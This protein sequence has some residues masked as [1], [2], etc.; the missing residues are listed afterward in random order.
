MSNISAKSRRLVT[1]VI[2]SI[3]VAASCRQETAEPPA[4]VLGQETVEFTDAG[5]TG[6]VTYEILNAAEGSTYEITLEGLPEWIADPVTSVWGEISFTVAENPG[7]ARNAQLTVICESTSVQFTVKQEAFRTHLTSEEISGCTITTLQCLY[8]E[9]ETRMYKYN[10]DKATAEKD[11]NGNYVY[12]T[13]GDWARDYIDKY[14]ADYPGSSVTA[15]EL[16][17]FD[18]TDMSGGTE[19]Y[20]YIKTTA[21]NMM[22]CRYGMR[23][24]YGDMSI[25]RMYGEYTYDEETGTMTVEDVGNSTYSRT[26]VF[27]IARTAPDM[28]EYEI[29]DIIF[30]YQPWVE[31]DSLPFF[32][33]DYDNPDNFGWQP[34]GKLLYVCEISRDE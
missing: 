12:M 4:I 30:P 11:E 33:P 6:K 20:L 18:F 29:T 34:C 22:E 5:G 31:G 9:E 24:E 2:V 23:D 27:E 8:F 19:N 15:D 28:C 3:A 16:M 10:Y 25:R 1:C 7:E 17:Y 13:A 26:V 14:L 21:D 32:H